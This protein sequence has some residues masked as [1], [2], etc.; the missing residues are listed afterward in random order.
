MNTG[1]PTSPTQS[2]V[3]FWKNRYQK[4]QLLLGAITSLLNRY[5]SS[6]EI[7]NLQSA[8]LLTLMGHYVVSESCYYQL[9]D[10]GQFIPTLA[11]GGSGANDLP[12]VSLD[13]PYIASLLNDRT[14]RRV[15]TLSPHR[16]TDPE[17][18]PLCERF[19]IVAPLHLDNRILGMVF[20]GKKVSGQVYR[21]V[22]FEV[23]YALCAVS[24]T[25]FN[26]ANLYRN[27]KLTAQ[28]IKKLHDVRSEVISRVSHEFR[29]PLTVIK[30]TLEPLMSDAESEP[31]REPL[32]ESLNRLEGLISSLLALSEDDGGTDEGES[33]HD[34]V[35]VV[36]DVMLAHSAS[37]RDKNIHF[38]LNQAVVS[39]DIAL[40]MP[41]ES[42]ATAVDALIDNAVKFSPRGSPVNIEISTRD[43]GPLESDG[44]LLPDWQPEA[45]DKGAQGGK[46]SDAPDDAGSN[47]RIERIRSRAERFFILRV[48]DEGIGI[49]KDEIAAVSEPFRQASN[50]PDLGVKGRGLGLALVQKLATQGAGYVSCW[51]SEKAGTTFSLFFPID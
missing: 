25:T 42:F 24:A 7:T 48:R 4:Q 8:F 37:A 41:R 18:A 9:E 44:Q 19:S 1:A 45:G 23:L 11:Y 5:G 13:N 15:A 32:R 21:D 46:S 6:L 33:C 17:M 14:P 26:N 51:T 3:D 34:P 43:A 20:L 30:A 50:S 38:V 47:R 49:P 10:T 27:A 12:A 39:D 35:A 29:T 2:L 40:A 36:H 22:D 16:V 31:W 28:E